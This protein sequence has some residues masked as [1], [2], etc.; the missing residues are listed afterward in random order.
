[1]ASYGQGRNGGGGG[2]TT[3]SGRSSRRA[4]SPGAVS[5]VLRVL[6]PDMLG[7]LS[8]V[9]GDDDD[10]DEV[11]AA[12]SE[13]LW[14]SIASFEWRSS[15]RTWV[16]V[17]AR[18]EM[19]RFRRGA[20]R[21]V[22]ARVSEL[23]SV[24]AAVQTET[25]GRQLSALEQAVARLRDELP[26]EDRALLVLR[27]D[28]ELPWDEIA[29]AFSEDPERCTDEERKREA[30]RLRKRFQLIKDRLARRAR[31]EGL[32]AGVTGPRSEGVMSS[33]DSIA[34]APAGG[35][36]PF[37][38][39]GKDPHGPTKLRTRRAE[40]ISRRPSGQAPES[41]MVVEACPRDTATVPLPAAGPASA[42]ETRRPPPWS[43]AVTGKAPPTAALGCHEA[44]VFG[45]LVAA[46]GSGPSARDVYARV[47]DRVRREIGDFGWRCS[48]RTWMYSLCRV[49]ELPPAARGSPRGPPR[50]RRR[51]ARDGQPD[52]RPSRPRATMEQ[53]P[54]PRSATGLDGGGSGAPD[55]QRRPRP[56]PARSRD[57]RGGRGRVVR[58]APRRGPPGSAAS[59]S[60]S[61]GSFGAGCTVEERLIGP[62][63]LP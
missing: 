10:A 1:M 11:F 45:F 41:R 62:H 63:G 34:P 8:R 58:P 29:L 32:L 48:L 53:P 59:C 38:S 49:E 26:E 13:R 18:N 31:A 20:Q 55:P 33:M 39:F 60:T 7:F 22:H 24:I 19:G 56:G 9:M 61:A 36:L 16:H 6:G 30:A 47:C 15:L 42:L 2:S 25:R 44:E 28:R 57:H 54:S 43:G 17:I 14:R 46:L 27:V 4:T 50:P 51:A 35:T 37:T 40:T 3:G 12:V 23:A 5:E 21:H 52:H